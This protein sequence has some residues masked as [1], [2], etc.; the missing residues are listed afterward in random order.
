MCVCVC[1]CLYI[2]IYIEERSTQ[3]EKTTRFKKA[4]TRG[5]GRNFKK[6]YVI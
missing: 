2:N 5:N 6:S 3:Q 1:V 4:A